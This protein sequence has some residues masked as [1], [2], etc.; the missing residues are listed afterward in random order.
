M[1][2]FKTVNSAFISLVDDCFSTRIYHIVIISYPIYPN[3]RKAKL[4]ELNFWD[5]MDRTKQISQNDGRK[6]AQLL[7]DELTK[8]S[9]DEIITYYKILRDYMGQAYSWN[10]WAAAYI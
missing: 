9:K 5:L 6:Q 8:L 1:T 7:V 2:T 3:R 10:L 4:N